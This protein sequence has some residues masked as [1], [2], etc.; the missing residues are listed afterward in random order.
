MELTRKQF[1]ILETMATSK[2]ALTQRDLEKLTK[3]SLGTINRTVKEL[4]DLDLV[5][6]GTITNKGIDAL[7]PYRAKRAV[8]IAAGFGS[9]LVPITFNTPK[10]LVRVHGVRIIDHLIDACLEA[11]I[12]EIFIVRGYLAEQ[13]DQLLYK[14]PM[15]K[16]LENPV[17]NEANNIS[18]SMIARY[19]L[20]NTYVFEADLLIS[21][22]KIIKKYH[23]TSDFLA[24]KKERTDDWCFEVK[25]GVI[26][27]EKVGGQ[28]GNVW[29]MV[30]ISYWNEAD[31]H[32][33]SVDI[34]DVY[35]SP[36]GK[37]RYWEQVP[38]VYK[39]EHYSVEV[40]ECFDE[41][42][43]EIDTFKEL[44]AIDKTYDV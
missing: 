6:N 41:D 36:G 3:Q 2:T 26:T 33:L 12:N 43:V 29:Q 10:P 37:E 9:R 31:G 11:G 8:F 4:T 38:L 1:D 27:E 13:F 21:N 17:Y 5:S 39:K 42:I 28:G 23:Y 40:R 44:K 34:P 19:M 24:I 22:P 18:S 20:S 32:R 15:I 14:Y 30:G 35:Q 25:D 7:E 16:F